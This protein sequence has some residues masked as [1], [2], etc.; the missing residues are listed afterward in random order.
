MDNV[1]I[2]ATHTHSAPGGFLMHTLFDIS[3]FGFS[4]QTFQAITSGIVKSISKAH[5]NLQKGKL[6]LTKG[7]VLN[8]NINRSPNA[9]EANPKEERDR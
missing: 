2:S 5:K 1:M 9:Y 4:N 3:S 8:A 7:E 6:F